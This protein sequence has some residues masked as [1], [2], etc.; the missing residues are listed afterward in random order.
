MHIKISWLSALLL[1]YCLATS[2]PANA[3][4]SIGSV[5]NVI[6]TVQGRVVEYYLNIPPDLGK[7]LDNMGYNSEEAVEEYFSWTLK[8]TSWSERCALN[9]LRA[10]VPQS[11]GNRIIHLEYTCP[12]EITDLTITS[13]VFLDIDE[14][15]IQF[16]KLAVPDNPGNVLQE[17]I[18]SLK[19]QVFHISDVKSGGSVMLYRAY[20]FFMLGTEH[21][22]SGYDHIL[23]ILASILVISGFIE[24]LK[25]VTAFTVAHSITLALAFLG[26]VSLSSSIVEPLIALT[27]AIVAFENIISR[28]FNKRW[29]LIFFF[30]LV[31]GLGFVGVLKE[32]TVSRQELITSLFSF[33]LGIEAGQLLIVGAGVFFLHFIRK[34]AWAPVAIRWSSISIGILGLVWFFERIYGIDWASSGYYL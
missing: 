31:H 26:I 23:F 3:H 2:T 4:E 32:I 6:I 29:V 16:I 27:I 21:I 9:K 19:N 12:R 14:K 22:L 10:I 24:L 18:L 25:L 20:R 15:H 30:G 28:N 11:S 7:L 8:L 1:S 34:A 33:N 13:S 5:S 17:D